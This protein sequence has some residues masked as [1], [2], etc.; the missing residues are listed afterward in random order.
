MHEDVRKEVKRKEAF[1]SARGGVVCRAD[2]GKHEICGYTGY[3][4]KNT[5]NTT[6]GSP[7][8]F[9]IKIKIHSSCESKILSK[10]IFASCVRY[11]D[12][13]YYGLCVLIKDIGRRLLTLTLTLTLTTPTPSTPSTPTS[14][15]P[16]P[17]TPSTPTPAPS[18][19]P[20]TTTIQVPVQKP[21]HLPSKA[22]ASVSVIK[23]LLEEALGKIIPPPLHC[24]STVTSLGN[25]RRPNTHNVN[26]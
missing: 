1:L 22:A 25:R 10:L 18:I 16:P 3:T 8:S 19:P 6:Q 24:C 4:N 9:I 15:I 13:A 20:P 7:L 14:S 21:I 5:V 23:L 26:T 17:S 11:S 2:D 12:R